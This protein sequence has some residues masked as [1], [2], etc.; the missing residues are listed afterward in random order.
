MDILKR[1]LAPITLEAWTEIDN[2]ARQTLIAVLSARKIVDVKGPLGWNYAAVPL[3]RLEVPPGQKHEEVRYG[4]HKVLP[5]LEIEA[6]FELDIWEVDNIV[7]GAQNID[8]S[9][10]EAAAHKV[11]QF[12]EQAI[13][14]GFPQAGIVGLKDATHH[15]G[16]AMSNDPQSILEQVTRGLTA[17]IQHSIEGPYALVVNPEI[18][19]HLS[20]YISGYPLKKHLE[21]QLGGPVILSPSIQ[22]AFLVSTRGGDMQLVL[23]Q[24]IGIGYR[25]HDKTNVSLYFTESFTFQVLVPE[26]IIY[27]AWNK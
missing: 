19:L 2:Q 3:G 25:R 11:A 27:Y 23:G 1:S 21:E 18:W 26:A 6:P 13:Y 14:Y 4:I 24:D 17:F 10:L 22:D 15:T 7:R 20:T 12:E 16:F 9:A 8:L 5:L